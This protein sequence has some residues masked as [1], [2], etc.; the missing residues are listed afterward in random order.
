MHDYFTGFL[1]KFEYF[2]V[3]FCCCFWKDKSISLSVK[4]KSLTN[5][6]LDLFY[7]FTSNGICFI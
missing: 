7:I 4:L 5:I 6:P 3:Y 2:F 1:I